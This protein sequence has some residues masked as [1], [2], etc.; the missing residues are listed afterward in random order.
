[1]AISKITHKGYEY[2]TE[3]DE[4]E[5][6]NSSSRRDYV[7]G[8]KEEWTTYRKKTDG[9]GESLLFKVKV[10]LSG[11]TSDTSIYYHNLDKIL[12][13][14]VSEYGINIL[15]GDLSEYFPPLAEDCYIHKAFKT[16]AVDILKN[17]LQSSNAEKAS[18]A[19]KAVELLINDGY[20]KEK[21]ESIIKAFTFALGWQLS[22]N[23]LSCNG[24]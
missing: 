20:K 16:G 2:T 24:T 4:D 23:E 15:L 8:A 9:S 11:I 10:E 5:L 17:N 18:A 3:Y 14:I 12:A 7:V 19:G 1:M 21:A 13:S 6:Y 22:C